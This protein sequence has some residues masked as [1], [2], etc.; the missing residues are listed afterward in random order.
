ML[1]VYNEKIRHRFINNSS[2]E[3]E[4]FWKTFQVFNLK[5]KY[6]GNENQ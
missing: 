2:Q 1:Q 6:D 3:P 5:R 4:R